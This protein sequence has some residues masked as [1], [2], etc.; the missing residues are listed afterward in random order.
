MKILY[1]YLFFTISFNRSPFRNIFV[2]NFIFH[3][4]K[5]VQATTIQ[6]V[7]RVAQEYL[8][9]ENIVTLVVGNEQEINPPLSQLGQTVK[10]IDVTI[11]GRAK[12]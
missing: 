9:T 12:S 3:Y 4:Q 11:Q 7:Q 6:E 2:I 5:G 10:S 8:K 1:Y